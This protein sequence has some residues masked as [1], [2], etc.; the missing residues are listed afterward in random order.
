MKKLANMG[1]LP[2]RE[3]KGPL[4]SEISEKR[5]AQVGPPSVKCCWKRWLQVL[6]LDTDVGFLGRALQKED[7]QSPNRTA[8][9]SQ[10]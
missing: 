4:V 6:P 7:C 1:L 2:G 5:L 3:E 10:G 8:L 9:L